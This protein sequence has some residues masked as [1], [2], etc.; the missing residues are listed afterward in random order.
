VNWVSW[1]AYQ[2][3]AFD[4]DN[5]STIEDTRS[6]RKYKDAGA[7]RFG[8]QNQYS[9]KLALRAGIAY[10]LTP[11][12]EGYV[13]PEV[14]DANRIILSA[15]LGYQPTEQLSVDFSFMYENVKSRTERNLE[16]QLDGTFKTLAFIPGIGVSYKF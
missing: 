5:N 15:G 1:N 16:T 2:Q 8:V 6:P 4:Y 3:L 14:P 9:E 13:T 10:A 12:R 7:V 11:V